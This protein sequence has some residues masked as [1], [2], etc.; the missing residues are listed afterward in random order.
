M[1][2]HSGAEGREWRHGEGWEGWE[3]G[4]EGREAARKRCRQESTHTHTKATS[5]YA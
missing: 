2:Y 4:R 1:A 3:R 5:K